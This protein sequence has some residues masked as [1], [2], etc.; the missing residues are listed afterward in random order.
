MKILKY[1]ILKRY[2]AVCEGYSLTMKL[3]EVG[4]LKG[5]KISITQEESGTFHLCCR[6]T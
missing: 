5:N 2:G 6:L 3:C 1:E 4:S